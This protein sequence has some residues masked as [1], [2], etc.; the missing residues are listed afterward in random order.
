MPELKEIELTGANTINIKNFKTDNFVG[1]LSGVNTAYFDLKAGTVKIDVS[2]ASKLHL[3]GSANLMTREGK[4]A[5]R[6]EML[7]EIG[8][9]MEKMTGQNK[10]KDIF[11][12]TFVM[13]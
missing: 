9:V 4:E 7:K 5:L 1:T 3:E 13:Q 12:T 10:V 8:S 2:G 6:A 11:F